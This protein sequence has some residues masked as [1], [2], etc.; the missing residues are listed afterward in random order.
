MAEYL[1]TR[2]QP[3][4]YLAMLQGQGLNWRDPMLQQLAASF[5]PQMAYEERDPTQ[6]ALSQILQAEGPQSAL[7]AKHGLTMPLEEQ[8][9]N[10]L[11]GRLGEGKGFKAYEEYKNKASNEY[12]KLLRTQMET[13]GKKG[14]G[15]E[16]VLGK[17]VQIL[18]SPN[19]MPGDPATKAIIDQLIQQLR[20][21]TLNLGPKGAKEPAAQAPQFGEGEPESVDQ[22]QKTFLVGKD[23][24]GNPMY[25]NRPERGYRPRGAAPTAAQPSAQAVD[26]AKALTPRPMPQTP[27]A[28][29]QPMFDMN[30]AEGSPMQWFGKL[31]S[32][33]L[34]AD[35]PDLSMYR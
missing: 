25:S 21:S 34:G 26:L 10:M 8:I 35:V 22:P 20:G 27:L 12:M 32:G 13:E 16:A 1:D 28:S 11:T 23:A 15:H 18:S 6:R 24:Y 19:Y 33:Q 5:F 31:L 14:V 30:P 2:N 7:S 9:F 17:L 29:P 3:S 4:P